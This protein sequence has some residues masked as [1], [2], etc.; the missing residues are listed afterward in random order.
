MVRVSANM[1]SG[2][3]RCPS[4]KPAM[5][6]SLENVGLLI[7]SLQ[8]LRYECKNQYTE[9]VHMSVNMH[10]G[11][12]AAH[13]EQLG[14]ATSPGNE[15]LAVGAKASDCMSLNTKTLPGGTCGTAGKSA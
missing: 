11:H 7:A 10:F 8:I 14:M 3:L 4:Q 15:H 12:C 9:V 5:A 13:Y 1:H 6:A 2:S